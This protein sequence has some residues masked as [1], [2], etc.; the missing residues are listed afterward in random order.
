MR[1]IRGAEARRQ[2]RAEGA[3][4]AEPETKAETGGATR[5]AGKSKRL[6]DYILVFDSAFL[7]VAS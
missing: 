3:D 2:D 7:M 4:A 5:R 1:S 6:F